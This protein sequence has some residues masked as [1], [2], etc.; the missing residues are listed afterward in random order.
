MVI[1]RTPI[2]YDPQEYPQLIEPILADREDVVFVRFSGG[3]SVRDFM[4]YWEPFLT[5]L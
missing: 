4:E 2:E 1:V 3:A 5:T